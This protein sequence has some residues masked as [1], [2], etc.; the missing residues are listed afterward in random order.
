MNDMTPTPRTQVKRI[1]ERG[2]YDFETITSILDAGF[3]CYV[4]YVIDGQP[5]VT[6]TA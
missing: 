1:P 4:G 5:Y 6:P 2:R 3:L